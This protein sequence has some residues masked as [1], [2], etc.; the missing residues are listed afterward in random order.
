[1]NDH[2]AY[3]DSLVANNRLYNFC[4]NEENLFIP[5]NMLRRRLRVAYAANDGVKV[6]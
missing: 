1:M 4:I 3:L 5:H 6:P 2:I